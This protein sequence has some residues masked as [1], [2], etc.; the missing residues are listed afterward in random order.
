MDTDVESAKIVRSIIELAKG[1]GMPTLA[2]GIEHAG[3][4]R[5]MM[6]AG[7][8]YGQGFYFGKAVPADEAERL[9]NGAGAQL[10]RA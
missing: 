9:A 8:E 2:E 7:A 4:M 5:A 3:T 6:K 10:R 1:L